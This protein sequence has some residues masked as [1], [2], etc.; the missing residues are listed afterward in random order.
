M[1]H[2][3]FIVDMKLNLFCHFMVCAD[4]HKYIKNRYYRQENYGLFDEDAYRFFREEIP[5]YC[6]ELLL[7]IVSDHPRFDVDCMKKSLD[8]YLFS[9]LDRK[10]EGYM[11]FWKKRES[12]LLALKER[13]E[14]QWLP[15]EGK[16]QS[17]LEDVFKEEV[18][19]NDLT[20]FLVDAY[21][22]R[23]EGEGFSSTAEVNMVD[24]N[25]FLICT[26]EPEQ[27]DLLF[28]IIVHEIIHRPLSGIMEQLHSEMNLGIDETNVVSETYARLIEKEVCSRI[29]IPSM[30]EEEIRENTERFG[31]LD[32]YLEASASWLD[33]I[34]DPGAYLKTCI[35]SQV[36]KDREVLRSCGY[37]SSFL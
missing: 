8:S 23:R 11:D 10:A 16:L 30:T 29:G 20:I 33:Y 3:Q 15:I 18:P 28:R 26:C 34:K 36:E 31:F 24:H 27:T 17:A 25:K 4:V 5:V 13:L 12:P 9:F 35:K 1:S 7:K 6:L 22:G 37:S 21:S 19:L 2:T 14:K 32:F